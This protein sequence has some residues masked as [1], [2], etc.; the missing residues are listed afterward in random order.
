MAQ[1]SKRINK[2][3]EEVYQIRVSCGY[4]YKGRQRTKTMTF[5]P[6]ATSPK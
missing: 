2:N 6:Q 4:D 1:I 3:G 5:K